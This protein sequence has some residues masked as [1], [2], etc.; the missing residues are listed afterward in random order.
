M[1]VLIALIGFAQKT[2]FSNHILQSIM[3]FR[4]A[5]KLTSTIVK[6]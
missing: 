1:L 5:I 3:Q 2:V 6:Y 4:K